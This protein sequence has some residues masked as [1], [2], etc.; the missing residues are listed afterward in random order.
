KVVLECPRCFYLD[1]RL[2]LGRPSM[3]GWALNSAV[4][5][6]LKREFDLLRKSGQKHELMKEY[7]INAIPF[8]HEDLPVWRGD[9][10]QFSG[11]K[12]LH[13]KTNLEIDGIID[14]LWVDDNGKL[15]IVDYKSTSTAKEISLEDEFKQ[16]YKKQVEIYQWIFTQ[17]GFDVSDTAY[18]VF[19][20][21]GKNRPNFDGRLEFDL[22]I[23]SHRGDFSWVESTL[24]EIKKTLDSDQLPQS[25]ENCEHCP[26]RKLISEKE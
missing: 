3:P 9:V 15:H 20:N 1:R 6:L 12:V 13:R 18:F 7:G 11:A 16:A 14:D 10:N 4:D 17:K 8:N 19:A 25:G 5:V 22:S 2:G 21:A 23:L 26:Y 24:E